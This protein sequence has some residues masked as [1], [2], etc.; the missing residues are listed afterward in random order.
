M[1]ASRAFGQCPKRFLE[2]RILAPPVIPSAPPRGAQNL[3]LSVHCSITSR[4]I[5][6]A[7]LYVAD[8]MNEGLCTDHCTD[9]SKIEWKIAI[10][11][12]QIS[13][14]A[15]ASRGFAPGP[16]WG[17]YSAPRPPAASG[18]GFGCWPPDFW[19]DP[20]LRVGEGGGLK[21]SQTQGDGKGL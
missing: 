1:L 14:I 16:H 9:R 6:E 8:V 13:R 4:C 11:H 20:P 18:L 3:F 7:P 19:L 2:N 5:I 17:A 10:S 21:F 15:K 12:H